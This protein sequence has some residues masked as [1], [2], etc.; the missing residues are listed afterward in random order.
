[1]EPLTPDEMDLA[2]EILRQAFQDLREEIY[3]TENTDFRANL[4]QR[5]ETLASAIRK[6]GGT[7]G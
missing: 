3:K 7:T 4:K 6:L 5:E 1:M 2:L